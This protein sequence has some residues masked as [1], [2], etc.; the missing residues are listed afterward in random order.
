MTAPRKRQSRQRVL[1]G[2]PHGVSALCIC[3]AASPLVLLCA[4]P[5]P[6]RS[7]TTLLQRQPALP[8]AIRGIL[9]SSGGSQKLD[10]WG[11]EAPPTQAQAARTGSEKPQRT[12][13][14][15]AHD[16]HQ[17][18]PTRRASLVWP[19]RTNVVAHSSDLAAPPPRAGHCGQHV[20]ARCCFS[21]RPHTRKLRPAVAREPHHVGTPHKSRRA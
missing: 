13:H 1:S 18:A 9:P 6:L 14:S 3:S 2:A 20:G 8:E 15:P 4:Q 12:A 10:G 5:S 17:G 19:Q 21:R 11:V 16:P 7:E